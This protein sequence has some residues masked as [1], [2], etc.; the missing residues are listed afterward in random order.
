MSRR[1]PSP[2]PGTLG[3]YELIERLG[4]G[5]MAEVW[6]ARLGGRGRLVAIK[7]VL[8]HLVAVPEVVRL[9]LAEARIASRLRHPNI[10]ETLDVGIVEGRPFL[11][12]EHLDGIDLGAALRAGPPPLGVCLYIVHAVAAALTYVHRYEEGGVPLGLVHRDV[13]PA[14]IRIGADGTV[15]LLDFG[16]AKA[17]N[18]ATRV[19]TRTGVVRG[20]LAYVAPEQLEGAFVSPASDQY[21]LGVVMH[22]LLRAHRLFPDEGTVA[23]ARAARRAPI[24]APLGR[25]HEALN[26]ICLRALAFDRADRFLGIDAMD[27]ALLP[28]LNATGVTAEH[29]ATWIAPYLQRTPPATPSPPTLTDAGG[30]RPVAARW[31]YAIGGLVLAS[32]VALAHAWVRRTR[33]EPAVPAAVQPVVVE[34]ATPVTSEPPPRTP[35]PEPPPPRRRR[36]PARDHAFD[37]RFP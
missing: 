21:S 33:P 4:A 14:N 25:E 20:K 11:V 3:A 37:A 34:R 13:S 5:G 17:V 22:E 15:R 28:W 23:Q 27:Q 18:D 9:F 31:R 7:R 19:R 36:P 8:P 26:E 1:S 35:V 16:I 24:P 6:S 10:V 30:G 2:R 32:A 29:A 12:M